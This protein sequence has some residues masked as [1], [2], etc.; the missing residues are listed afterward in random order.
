[1]NSHSE[2]AH[3]PDASG[4]LDGAVER[5][6]AVGSFVEE[7]ADRVTKRAEE[8]VRTVKPRLRGWIHLFTAPVAL[9]AG[10]I[11]AVVTPWPERLA[12]IIFAMTSVV[13]FTVS[14]IYHRG[15]W[16]PTVTAVL[17]RFDHANIFLLIAGTYT[18]LSA[19]LLPP[20]SARM[21]LAIVWS[22]ALAGILLQVIWITAP[23]WLYV[24]IYVILGWVAVWFLPDFWTAGS[25]LLVWLVIAGGLAY[26][27]GALAY[28]LKRPNPWPRYFGFHEIFHTGT[29]VGWLC[30]LIAVA[31]AVHTL[32]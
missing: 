2:R 23:R 7:S 4:P 8:L 26:T 17:R 16:S 11:L 20:H 10:I 27:F 19:I 22:G 3:T 21:I 14:A 24:P 25:P 31:L 1:M 28:G 29:V 9:V 18:P 5:V 15:N 12:V 6:R 30:H 13:L 32:S